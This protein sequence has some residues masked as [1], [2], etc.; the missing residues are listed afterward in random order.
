MDEGVRVRVCIYPVFMFIV[1]LTRDTSPAVGMVEVWQLGEWKTI[2]GDSWD[3]N[4]ARVVCRQ[5]G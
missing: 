3:D 2:C 1:R 4:D 5:L